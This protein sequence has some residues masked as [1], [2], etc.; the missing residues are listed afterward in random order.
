VT[1]G[2]AFRARM[3]DPRLVPALLQAD[4]LSADL[5]NF[6]RQRVT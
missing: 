2:L 5:K 4:A 6:A 1:I 3:S